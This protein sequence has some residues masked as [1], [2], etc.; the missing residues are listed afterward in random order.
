MTLRHSFSDPIPTRELQHG[1]L[2]HQFFS[3]EDTLGP[4]F[5]RWPVVLR[6]LAENVARCA[7]PEDQTAMLTGLR[8]WVTTGSSEAEVH[9]L[10]GRL[11]MH[12][13]TSTPAL[14]DIAAMR[15]AVAA[16]GKDP[17]L[18]NPLLPVEV[19]V[20]HSLAVE[21]YATPD[22]ARENIR[23]EIRRNRERYRFLKWASTSMDNIHINPPGTGI[24]H[25]INLEQ[26]A[27]VVTTEERNG[28]LLATPDMMLGTDS[29]TPMI[30]GL[31]VLGWGVG[32]LE[33]ETV[34]FGMPTTLKIPEVVGVHLEGQLPPGVLATDLALLVTHELRKLGVTGEFV[35]FYGPGVS[36]LSVGDR[37][38]IANMA[39]EY[40]ATTGYFP[41]DKAV[42]DYLMSTGRSA[43][44]CE[45]VETYAQA[46]GLWFEPAATP[47][48]SREI[49]IDLSTLTPSAAGPRRPQDRLEL[50]AIPG[51]LKAEGPAPARPAAF[52]GQLPEYPVALAS[53]TSCTNTS[54]PRLLI[55]AGLLARNARQRGLEP[56]PWVKTSLAPGSPAARSYLSRSGLAEDL[57]AVGFDIVGFGCA[58]C[59]GNS[60]PLP[61]TIEEVRSEGSSRPVA[62]LSGNRNFPGRV[63]PDLEFGFLMSP[64][65][66]IAYALAGDAS[67]NLATEPV[68]VERS[69]EPVFLTDL[70]PSAEEIDAAMTEALDPEDFHR[71][72]QAAGQSRL[73]DSI[74]TPVGPLFPWD[75]NSTILRPPPFA[76]ARAA[77][78]LKRIEAHP[79]LVLGDDITT[80]HISPA[81]AVPQDSFIADFLVERGEP[82]DD[83]NV[84]ASR[85]G[86]WEVMVR[87]AYYAKSVHNH[88][89]PDAG[90]AMTTY[91]PT[92][93]IM[94]IWDASQRYREQGI[95]VV[96]IAGERYGMGS[97]RD[98]AAK[99]QQLL[100]VGV[101]LAASFE[102]IH[103][104]N[105][106][107][108]GILPLIVPAETRERLRS[109][110]AD[111]TIVIDVDLNN[112]VPRD[113]ISVSVRGRES[114]E[115]EWS[116]D[117]KA[118]VETGMDVELLKSGGVI[119]KILDS[120]LN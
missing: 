82:R 64:P 36:E 58:T 76:A 60:G 1:G 100:G 66:V 14:V 80:D 90:T 105:L 93:E 19:S 74:E 119:P 25:T 53:I 115:E 65:L 35:E 59:I 29:H 48:F 54:D 34:M 47:V 6:L 108:M 97:S 69:G 42:L 85:R 31:G 32:G 89:A 112:L 88:L 117:A 37:A 24:M 106:I 30:N 49:S 109:V 102:R 15:D 91:G 55:T 83:L 10:P 116:F 8:D 41:I 13:T 5:Q 87:G 73:W 9:Y 95:P 3:A 96:V 26:L 51:T 75:D 46:A 52:E 33:A 114:G 44:Q 16:E 118:G 23:H 67:R 40:G 101:V 56:A 27:T 78:L 86:N 120:L 98:W 21:S 94:P 4:D 22:A 110:Q 113:T 38:V 71:D 28:T 81:S 103:R 11:L 45:L 7:A 84:F 12:D 77:S 99:V 72:F 2:R 68:A 107:G 57:S 104:S 39:P 62:M 43:A 50:S 111:S 20:D 63:H 18:L 61:S 92:G 70:W 79:L 17:E